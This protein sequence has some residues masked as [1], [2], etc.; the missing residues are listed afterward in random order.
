MPGSKI[1]ASKNNGIKSYRFLQSKIRSYKRNNE[2]DNTVKL[3]GNKQ[4]LLGIY[5]RVENNKKIKQEIIDIK[6]KDKSNKITRSND[7]NIKKSV[8]VHVF[9]KNDK[10]NYSFIDLRSRTTK[11]VM[12][13]KAF[14]IS[15]KRDYDVPLTEGTIGY[16]SSACSDFGN[17]QR[18][19]YKN[20]SMKMKINFYKH[21][22]TGEAIAASVVINDI[23]DVDTIR[24]K[25]NK[26]LKKNFDS[27][28]YVI[29]F[30][31][32]DLLIT[33]YGTE[34]GCDIRSHNST[35]PY[36]YKDDKGKK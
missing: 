10:N 23:F 13:N 16:I 6:N 20:A 24:D 5:N 8:D 15:Y 19:L 29:Y 36:T 7:T 26:L 9:L 27:I 31:S 3:N 17:N 28:D 4:E 11:N 32:I 18:K 22:T 34:G 21:I 35:I 14:V 25:L 30:D 12:N 1:G 33:G 2:I